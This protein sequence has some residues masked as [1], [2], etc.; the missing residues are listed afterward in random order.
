MRGMEQLTSRDRFLLVK[1]H[2]DSLSS[3]QTPNAVRKALQTLPTSVFETYDDVLKRIED[4][5]EDDRE[6]AK[7]VLMW[8]SLSSRPLNMKELQ[9]AVII[10][11][12]FAELDEDD[13]P[14]EKI[15][16]SVCA[17]LVSLAAN[18][19]VVQLVHFTAQ[20]YFS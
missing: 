15:I 16:V 6:L 7:K 3:K 10:D 4:Q 18:G 8:L 19:G 9:H 11:E 1:L 5:N 12:S 2:M 14:N 20:E 17:G 13:V